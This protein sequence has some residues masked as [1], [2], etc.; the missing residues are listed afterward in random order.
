MC[1]EVLRWRPIFPLTPDHVASRDIEFE[2]YYFPAGTGFT[3]NGPA[4]CAECEEPDRFMPERWLDGYEQDI[5][6]GLWQFGG[7]RRI[8][9]GYRLAQRSLFVNIARLVQCVDY[10]PVGSFLDFPG[11][12]V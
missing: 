7:G 8:C 9:V 3:I 1:K 10:E 2:G 4:V 6:H 12:R 5:A 11:F